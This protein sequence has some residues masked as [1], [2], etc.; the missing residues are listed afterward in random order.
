MSL[1]VPLLLALAACAEDAGGESVATSPSSTAEPAAGPDEL[2]LRV[3]HSGGFV[4]PTMLA[5]RL[6]LFSLYADGRVVTEGP[7]VLVYPP[8][9][10]PNV[11]VSRI[12]PADVDRLVR[13]A[14]DAGVTGSADLGRPPV[15]DAPTTRFSVRTA[16]GT[17]VVQAYALQ[18]TPSGARGVTAAQQAARTRLQELL[19][20]LTNL[21]SVLGEGAVSAQQ[22]YVPAALAAVATPYVEPGAPEPP[23]AE[24]EWFGPPLPG[25]AL[26]TIEG[27]TCVVLG[28]EY[29]E[30]LEHLS[31]TA[32]AAT[33]WTYGGKRW[34]VSL[35]PLLPDESGCADLSA[36]R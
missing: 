36:R 11:Q 33:P 6:P 31:S 3:D 29:L 19:D 18:E 23:Q 9:A 16:S 34:S 8:P 17:Q 25:E 32:T 7:Q 24:Q 10:L 22:P 30:H 21:D 26:G 14:V 27:L 15:A 2:I 4:T 1:L 35:R 28:A 13:M 5:T 20:A 12:Q